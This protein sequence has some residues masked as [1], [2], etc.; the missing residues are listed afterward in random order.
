MPHAE[1]RE[2]MASLIRFR[3]DRDLTAAMG[4]LLKLSIGFVHFS[5]CG[6]LDC[7]TPL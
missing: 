3:I 4:D 5:V 2:T 6:R 1:R 7:W